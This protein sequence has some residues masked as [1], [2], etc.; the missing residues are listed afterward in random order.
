[1]EN[2]FQ[3]GLQIAPDHFLG[4]AIRNGWNSKRP[5]GGRVKP[6]ILTSLRRFCA[7][8]VSVHSSRVGLVY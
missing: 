3:N 5:L 6:I 2:G 8:A 7:M 1:M 4:A